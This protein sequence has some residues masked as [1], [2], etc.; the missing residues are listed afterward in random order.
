MNWMGHQEDH[1]V[2]LISAPAGHVVHRCALHGNWRCLADHVLAGVLHE[3]MSSPFSTQTSVLIPDFG[4]GCTRVTM[5]RAQLGAY[6]CL[7]LG[8]IAQQGSPGAALCPACHH[9]RFSDAATRRFTGC[10]EVLRHLKV[11]HM[12]LTG[13]FLNLKPLSLLMRWNRLSLAVCQGLPSSKEGQGR[14]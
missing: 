12:F 11:H 3:S 9:P 13:N 14:P 6:I 8:A 5:I 2:F 1:S 7:D 4:A 10:V